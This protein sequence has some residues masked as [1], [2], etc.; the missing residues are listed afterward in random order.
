MQTSSPS[1]HWMILLGIMV[2]NIFVGVNSTMLALA[3]GTIADDF[4]V[5]LSHV[6]WI[7]TVY[8]AVMAIVLPV[9]GKIGDTI[10]SKRAFLI[11]M[12]IFLGSSIGSA[13]SDSLG[14]LMMFRILQAVG[15]S[16]A[17]PNAAGILRHITPAHHTG[18]TFGALSS[19]AGIGSALGPFLGSLFIESMGWK[20]IFLFGTPF[21]CASI[22][23]VSFLVPSV[24]STKKTVTK[25]P[26]RKHLRTNRAFLHSNLSIFANNLYTYGFIL[27][28][29]IVLTQQLDLSL[30]TSGMVLTVFFMSYTLFSFIGGYLSDLYRVNKLL[31][32]SYLLTGIFTI[33][34]LWLTPLSLLPLLYGLVILTGATVGIGFSAS[35]V[36]NVQSVSKDIAA[37]AS[38]VYQTFRYV[39]SVSASVLVSYTHGSEWFFILLFIT[40]VY[41][42]IISRDEP[43]LTKK[44]K[45][46]HL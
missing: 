29:P 40:C 42:F 10:G 18:K 35:Q 3:L 16:L 15:G 19:C 25:I 6:S 14:T 27:V 28:L 45:F 17:L 39:G 2:G 1:K 44:I 26:V 41:G 7:M 36:A 11:G 37:G 30:S 33:P 13:F 31:Q 43:L 24:V 4:H 38:G 8:L 12:W 9:S 23:L 46:F 21:T 22:L 5:S 20:F 34:Y 32:L